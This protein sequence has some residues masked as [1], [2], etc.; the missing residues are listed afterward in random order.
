MTNDTPSRQG[1]FNANA[2]AFDS[3][4]PVQSVPFLDPFKN[5]R[6]PGDDTPAADD[7]PVIS[8]AAWMALL[9]WVGSFGSHETIG[10]RHRK[11]SFLMHLPNAPQSYR[12]LANE[13][14]LTLGS[15]YRE[16]ERSK[17][18]LR[19]IIENAGTDGDH[20]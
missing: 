17:L 20:T 12:S 6:E 2:P 13:L 9:S 16:V 1:Y 10:R 15:C 7:Q 18:D 8:G 14:G 4:G 11:L 19:E 3:D 5:E